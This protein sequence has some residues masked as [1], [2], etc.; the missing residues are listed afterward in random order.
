MPNTAQYPESSTESC[1]ALPEILQHLS[2]ISGRI[3]TARSRSGTISLIRLLSFLVSATALAF[4]AA[5]PSW[6]LGIL[7]ALGPVVFVVAFLR[8]GAVLEEI[9]WL[10]G[11]RTLLEERKERLTGRRRS[12]PVSLSGEESRI[13]LERGLTAGAAAPLGFDLEPGVIDDLDLVGGPRSLFGFLDISSTVFGARR[14]LG[15]L[16]HPLLDLKAIQERQD[17]VRR[18]AGASSLVDGLLRALFTLRKHRFDE[19][20][21]TLEAPRSLAGSRGL[22]L[23]ANLAGTAAPVLLLFTCFDLRSGVLLFL[24]LVLNLVT[25]GSQVKKTN[26]SRDRLLL[27]GPLLN[28]LGEVRRT[29]S[30]NCP[31]AAAWKRFASILQDMEEPGRRLRRL[32]RLLELHELGIFFE[33]LNI[34]TLWELRLLPIAESLLERNR[35]LLERSVLALGEIEAT[36]SLAIPLL[37]QPGFSIPEPLDAP[38]PILEMEALGHPLIEP[39]RL[40]LNDVRLDEGN[41]IAIITGSNMSGKSTLLKAVGTNLILAGMGGPVQARRMRWTPMAVSSDIN[42]RDSLDDGKSYFAV[43]VERVAG[44]LRRAR[45][46]EKIFAIFDELFRGTNSSER[47]AIGMAL[48]AHLRETGG[49]Y[50][51]AT[52]DL[53]MTRLEGEIPG[54]ANFH[55]RET[56]EA[57]AMRFDYRLR[58]G[59]APTRNA[60]R[61]L[62]TRGYPEGLVKEARERLSGIESKPG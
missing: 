24:A 5:S 28:G 61:V 49:L 54:I 34:L 26:P 53:A 55:F 13:P 8:H 11:E 10:E 60:I 33:V 50:L 9:S 20:P 14:L 3:G 38:A 2:E 47:Q 44:I 22:L 43:E 25:I 15:M 37:E 27:L 4:F 57:G 59:P 18:A 29:L 41:P 51:V 16:R 35:S 7:S 32:I 42:V 1:S 6:P 62:E 31:E 40:V 58:P 48:L 23:W 12:R 52:H 21:A 45:E 36:L 30:E 46:G 17:A 56:V 39:E 19:I